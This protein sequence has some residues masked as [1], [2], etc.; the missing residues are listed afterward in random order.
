MQRMGKFSAAVN[1]FRKAR[2]RAALEVILA[3]LTGKS[4]ELLSFDDVRQK[5]KAGGSMPR[6]E[7][8]VPLDAI[9]GSVG[10]YADFTRSFL[11]RQ[12]SDEA[13]WA[14]I[15]SQDD[16]MA[17]PPIEVYQIGEAYFVLDGNHRVSVARQKG[18]RYIPAYV[19]EVQTRVPLSP[20]VQPDDLII[21][22]EAA[23][24]LEYTRLNESCPGAD[25]TV[26]IP[27]QYAHLEN[28]IEVHRYFLEE[29]LG[30][31]IPLE[32]AACHWH[33]NA[34]LPVV[35]VIREQ[36]ILQDFPG[37]TETDLYLWLS[38]HRVA[39]RKELGLDIQPE[40]AVSE[41]ADRFSPRPERVAARIARKVLNVVLPAE[42]G[43]GPP[44]GQWRKERL[45]THRAGRLFDDLLVAVSGEEAGWQALDQALEIARREQAR[46]YGFHAAASEA[47]A[48]LERAKAVEAEF[49]RRC[50]A[51]GLAGKLAFEVG[52]VARQ[53]SE[54]SWWVDLIVLSLSYPPAPQPLAR[55]ASG[56][57]T[58]L[59]NC[60]RPVL[61]VPG[62]ASPLKRALLAY[63][64]SPRADE[65][66]FVAT[67]LA[68]QRVMPLVVLT[69]ET[70]RTKL[71]AQKRAQEYLTE[72]GVRATFVHKSGPAAE[73]ILKTVE[74]HGCDLII[75][76]SYGPNPL[77]EVV[78]GSTV[79]DVLRTSRKPVLICR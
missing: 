37:R 64:G 55:L 47:E 45:V 21:K 18:F 24:F 66:L 68:G 79:D 48:D 72:H 52:E 46:V 51:V 29:E 3:R 78:M 69:V 59:R 35:Q 33:N 28:H 12:D 16:L 22:A 70:D 74:E 11:P 26:S 27:G 71:E 39:I 9:V 76:G 17:L 20:D 63:D 34:Y 30:H 65:A 5:L 57:R 50:Q 38:Q 60:A 62:P 58:I 14:Q 7:Q 19:Y 77:V 1:D 25:L 49:H 43:V 13:R 36:G 75:M 31:D 73:A 2:Q 40:S 44:P 23:A 61:A 8:D 41:L 32:E 4:A 56:F 67:Y 54:R 6:G 15:G 42:M 53:I 10:R